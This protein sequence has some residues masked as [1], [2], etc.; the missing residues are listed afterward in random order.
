MENSS[1][2]ETEMDSLISK[3]QKLSAKVNTTRICQPKEEQK[4]NDNFK[5]CFKEIKIQTYSCVINA[6]FIKGL[7]SPLC[8][9]CLIKSILEN[10]NAPVHHN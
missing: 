7:F 2:S 5:I 4:V 10:K 1:D 8:F 6:N 3:F 9:H